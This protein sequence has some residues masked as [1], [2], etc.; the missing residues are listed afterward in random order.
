VH[1]IC[2]TG[3]ICVVKQRYHNQVP[4]S[5]FMLLHSLHFPLFVLMSY[6]V[7]TE[8]VVGLHDA[9]ALKVTS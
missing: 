7:V 5:K 1:N 3:I 2:S 8:H 6:S 9:G 4:T